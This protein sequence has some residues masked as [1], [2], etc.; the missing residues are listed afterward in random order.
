MGWGRCDNPRVPRRSPTRAP[1]GGQG[2]RL[3]AARGPELLLGVLLVTW[4]VVLYRFAELRH[5]R[6]GTFGFDLGIYDQA[7]WLV[8][9]F[10]P[11]FITVRGLDVWG[12][13]GTFVFYLLAPGYWLGGGATWLLAAQVAGQASGGLALYLLVRDLMG[14]QY[15]WLGVGAAA[16]LLLHPTSQWLVWEFFHPDS[17]AIGP[18]L[19]AWWAAR[20]QRWV[21]FAAFAVVAASC[22]ED[23]V[24]SIAMIGV[25]VAFSRPRTRVTLRVGIATA[26]IAV[27]WYLLVTRW[28]IPA[29]NPFGAFYEQ[30]FFTDFGQSTGEIA[31]NVVSDPLH[32]LSFVKRPG[33]LEWY[34]MMF[35]PVL[36]TCFW[37]PKA[38]LVAAPMLAVVLLTDE[39][40][41]FVRIFWYHYSAI[42]VAVVAL[43]AVE[44]VI[45]LGHR[46]EHRT[47]AM[48]SAPHVLVGVLLVMGLLSTWLWGVFPGARRA[49][50]GGGF[51]PRRPG[52]SVLDVVLGVDADRDPH[53]AAKRAAVATVPPDARVSAVYNVTPHLAHRRFVYQFPNPWLPENWGVQ[54]EGQHDPATVEWLLVDRQLLDGAAA[55]VVDH[56]LANEFDV[57][58]DRDDV[59]LARRRGPPVCID[60][61]SGA[62]RTAANDTYYVTSAPPSTG[63]VCP[64]T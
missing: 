43:A 12:H 60:D 55:I 46:V 17:L 8:A 24:L 22:K 11:G 7:G 6:F 18:L 31:W 15:R 4:S 59:V 1:I 49:E 13:H 30:Q 64:V 45:W 40:H 26:V 23:V 14:R 63:K 29:Y 34:R 25:V 41:S 2:S 9:N 5:D 32:T 16:V 28:M 36:F 20:T 50:V 19:L 44:S 10:E 21:W 27:V 38:M 62:V 61:P 58:S 56:L 35:A 48:R 47:D 37:R 57:V 42:P 3:L 39:G 51:W 54:D 33:H 53:A 52:E